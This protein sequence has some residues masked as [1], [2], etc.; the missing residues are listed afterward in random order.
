MAGNRA[1]VSASAGD[2]V[3]EL[4]LGDGVAADWTVRVEGG[5]GG[6]RVTTGSSADPHPDRVVLSASAVGAD[7]TW[8]VVFFGPAEEVSYH[9]R[10]TLTQGGRNVLA[11]PIRGGG[12]VKARRTKVV[13]GTISLVPA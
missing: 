11:R 7:L 3:L 9:Y 2:L 1:T 4:H 13:S 12:E 5:P 8:M 10:L 6:A